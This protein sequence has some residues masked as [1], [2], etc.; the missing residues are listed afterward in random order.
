MH[1]ACV[2]HIQIRN[3]PPKLHRRLKRQAATAGMSLN[4]YLLTELRRIGATPSL[5]ELTERVRSRAL[6]HFDESSAEIL[7]RERD[8]E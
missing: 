1:N 5:T 4:E 2:T 3:V 6:F 7:R 8:R